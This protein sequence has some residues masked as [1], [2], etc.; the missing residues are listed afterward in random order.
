VDGAEN[1][2][3]DN[4]TLKATGIPTIIRRRRAATRCA[5]RSSWRSGRELEV[6]HVT[7]RD[8]PGFTVMPESYGNR[9]RAELLAT[10]IYSVYARTWSRRVH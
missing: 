9:T 4:G 7:F 8:F 5:A 1:N 6:D 3:A 2:E 10:I